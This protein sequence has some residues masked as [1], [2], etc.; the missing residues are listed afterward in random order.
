MTPTRGPRPSAAEPPAAPPLDRAVA[1][2]E[3]HLVEH[4]RLAGGLPDTE[5]HDDPD[6]TWVVQ[7]LG[8]AWANAGVRIRFTGET[9]AARLDALIERYRANG[10]GMGLWVSPAAT[11]HDLPQLLQARRLRCRHH[12]PAM[13]WDRATA[14]PPRAR[15]AGVRIQEITSLD[16]L[17]GRPHPAIG[18][19]TTPF[20]RFAVARLRALLA[21]PGRPVR[22]LVAWL[23]D[24][25][26][27]AAEMFL[28][29]SCAGL[30]GL[31]VAERCQGRG[32]GSALVDRVCAIAVEA[33][34]DR[35]ALL[36][37][38]EGERVYT[39]RGFVEIAPFGYYYRSF[40]QGRR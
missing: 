10:R 16:D 5:L 12:F 26:V 32:I 9:A 25:P 11:P 17:G 30:H 13:R 6:V 22:S 7:P 35:V 38:T 20:R 15:P 29:A 14:P 1:L 21:L 39:R 18:P 40:Q 28:G 2:I 37:T 33:G 27:G 3:D 4:S 24:E 31:G 23:D 34:R 8:S 19:P 36:A